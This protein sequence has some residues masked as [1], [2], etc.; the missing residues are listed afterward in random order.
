[1]LHGIKSWKL[2]R[3]TRTRALEYCILLLRTASLRAL[4]NESW[5]MVCWFVIH[6][7]GTDGSC[8]SGS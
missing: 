8:L 7:K 3:E 6:N 4:R 1:M 2:V 5:K